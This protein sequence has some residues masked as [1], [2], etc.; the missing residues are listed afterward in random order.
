M[1]KEL[2]RLGHYSTVRMFPTQSFSGELLRSSRQKETTENV[3]PSTTDVKILARATTF[4][5]LFSTVTA[6][7]LWHLLL[8]NKYGITSSCFLCPL[9]T[10]G[11]F[12]HCH[13]NC[14]G[15]SGFCYA[16][17]QSESK[18]TYFL[19]Q[20]AVACNWP[21]YREEHVITLRGPREM[22]NTEIQNSATG[23]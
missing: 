2:Q 1:T 22:F 4:S 17:I 23:A 19:S 14:F 3:F 18:K 11:I 10:C 12:I 20:P 21:N 8:T 15:N 6:G 9:M 5:P 7:S 16:Y 13:L